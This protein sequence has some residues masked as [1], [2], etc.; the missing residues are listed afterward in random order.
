MW[1]TFHNIVHRIAGKETKTSAEKR[2]WVT[3]SIGRVEAFKNPR[4]LQDTGWFDVCES[5]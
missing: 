5:L 1:N 4:D 2:I 3:V